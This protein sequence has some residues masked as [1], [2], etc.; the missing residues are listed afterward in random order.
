M[1]LL[2]PVTTANIARTMWI[3]HIVPVGQSIL[4]QAADLLRHGSYADAR[5]A[6]RSIIFSA[7]AARFARRDS[8]KKK[9]RC[10]SVQTRPISEMP[11]LP[12]KYFQVYFFIFY[13]S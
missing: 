2:M 9:Y 1:L 12:L 5:A 3:L 13:S 10:I 4:A 8:C 6:W 11:N 7:L